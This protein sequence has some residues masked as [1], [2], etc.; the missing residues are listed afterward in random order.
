MITKRPSI[1]KTS[2]SSTAIASSTSEILP[3]TLPPTLQRRNSKLTLHSGNSSKNGVPVMPY[4][5]GTEVEG[6]PK[7]LLLPKLHV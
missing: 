3:L 7:N 1:S 6:Q 2:P 5:D 4:F